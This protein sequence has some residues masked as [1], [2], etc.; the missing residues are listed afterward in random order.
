ML[1]VNLTQL[2]G[3]IGRKPGLINLRSVSHPRSHQIHNRENL[4]LK[5]TS[6]S[7]NYLVRAVGVEPT[8]CH[9]NRILSPARLPIPPRPQE[10]QTPLP[11]RRSHIAFGGRGIVFHPS[12]RCGDHSHR[13][14]IVNMNER[15]PTHSFRSCISDRPK[16]HSRKVAFRFSLRMM[17]KQTNL[18]RHSLGNQ[19]MSALIDAPASR[20]ITLRAPRCRQA[21]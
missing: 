13:R 6:Y 5:Q 21:G 9:Q 8:L 10:L 2:N 3:S 4:Q 19:G 16:H 17:R 12:N 11:R 18:S 15:P 7:L 20:A 1:Q 14:L